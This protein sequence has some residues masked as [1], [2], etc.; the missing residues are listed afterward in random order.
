MIRSLSHTPTQT[1]TPT[2][3]LTPTQT[4]CSC[5]KSSP[6]FTINAIKS[7]DSLCPCTEPK[8]M[9]AF[10]VAQGSPYMS[11][12][13]AVRTSHRSKENSKQIERDQEIC[14]KRPR[15]ISG[16]SPYMSSSSA[17][18]ASHK[19]NENSKQVERDLEIWEKRPRNTSKREKRNT[20]KRELEICQKRPR[21]ISGISPYMFS[22]SAVCASHMSKENSKYVERDL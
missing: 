2:P 22:S 21:N 16:I 3:T 17:V 5:R 10:F 19:S 7:H 1:P 13:S 15:N 6:L 8:R 4:T 14:Q 9:R 12:S 11:S 20:S 18:R